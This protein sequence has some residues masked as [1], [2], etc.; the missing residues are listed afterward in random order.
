MPLIPGHRGR[1]I[2]WSSRPAWPTKQVLGQPRL[3][4]ETIPQEENKIKEDSRLLK[5]LFLS[6]T[7]LQM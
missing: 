7:D 6:E 3:H 5:Y 2:S 1:E 4:K